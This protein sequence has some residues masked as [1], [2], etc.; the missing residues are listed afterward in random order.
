V[1]GEVHRQASELLSQIQSKPG[2]TVSSEVVV[3]A[4]P[5]PSNQ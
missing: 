3:P 5:A 2:D 1:G 4:Q